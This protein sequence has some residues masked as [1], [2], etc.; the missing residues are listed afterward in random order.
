MFVLG[1]CYVGVGGID[2]HSES[3]RA[4]AADSVLRGIRSSSAFGRV[5]ELSFHHGIKAL[6][7]RY[8]KRLEGEANLDERAERILLKLKEIRQEISSREYQG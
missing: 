1:C 3:R 4:C 6:S 2:N 5:E 8:R 7:D